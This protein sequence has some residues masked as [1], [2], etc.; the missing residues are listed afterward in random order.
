MKRKIH[1]KKKFNFFKKKINFIFFIIILLI[2]MIIIVL[3]FINLKVNPILLDYAEMESR[4]IASII[5]NDAVKQ[6]ITDDIDVDELFIITKDA[7]NEVKTI[8][9]NPIIVNQI[10]TETTLVVQSNLR[11]LEQ[12][13]IEMLNLT[14]DALID[15]NQEKLKQGIIYEIPSGVIFGNSFL[16]NLGPKIPVRFSLVGDI[17]GYINTDVTDYGINNALIEVNIILELSEQVILP[18]V[19]EKIKIETT[20]PVA[21]KLI[22]GSVPNYYLNGLNSP[23]FALPIN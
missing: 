12:G 1:L 15:Y 8:D 22:Q 9:F 14:D 5:I 4:K 2:I 18:F 21:L 13:K 7:N 20:I 19:T 17:V 11:Y 10:L 23:S 16:A 6:N 3:N